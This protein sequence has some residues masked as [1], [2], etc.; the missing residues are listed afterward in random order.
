MAIGSSIFDFSTSCSALRSCAYVHVIAL[1]L[2]LLL[3]EYFNV[4]GALFLTAIAVNIWYSFAI[5]LSV[6]P[7][8]TGSLGHRHQ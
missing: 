5:V 2:A 8:S 7:L 6:A 4:R 1:G 3:Q